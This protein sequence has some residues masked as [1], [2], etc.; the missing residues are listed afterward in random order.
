MSEGD[1]PGSLASDAE[2]YP[3]KSTIVTIFCGKG[4]RMKHPIFVRIS[5]FLALITAGVFLTTLNSFAQRSRISLDERV[6][7]MTDKLSLTKVQSDSLRA[8]YE[9]AEKDR[10][11]AFQAHKDDRAAMRDAI[12]KIMKDSDEKVQALLTD[13]QQAKWDEIKKERPRMMMGG[14]KKVD[15][16]PKKDQ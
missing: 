3:E 16:P 11:A 7:F 4:T 6:K 5:L 12:G 13:K 14:P 8:I 2:K 9:A 15:A 10:M 1:S